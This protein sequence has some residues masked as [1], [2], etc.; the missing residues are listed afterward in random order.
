M[1][2]IYDLHLT[3]KEDAPLTSKVI[4]S[5]KFNA[6]LVPGQTV[7]IDGVPHTVQRVAHDIVASS[8]MGATIY[9]SKAKAELQLVSILVKHGEI[10]T[11]L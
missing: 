8:G 1:P 10:P 7:N 9:N 4:K 6:P 2:N 5:V 11:Q 3:C